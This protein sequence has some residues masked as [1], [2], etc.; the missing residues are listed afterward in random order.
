MHP[1]PADDDPDS[2][3]PADHR[4]VRERLH[5]GEL[6]GAGAD[7]TQQLGPAED[8][9]GADVDDQKV[10]RQ[11]SVQRAGVGGHQCV[12]EFLVAGK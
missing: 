9:T 4:L 10:R 5:R 11:Q 2:V 8:R 3:D 12:E 6:D 7:R 1:G